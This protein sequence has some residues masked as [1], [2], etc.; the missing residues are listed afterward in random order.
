M[1]H[2]ARLFLALLLLALLA[3]V[4]IPAIASVYNATIGAAFGSVERVLRQ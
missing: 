4:A 2:V 3:S 1:R